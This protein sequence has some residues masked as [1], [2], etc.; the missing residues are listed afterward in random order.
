M[1]TN[2]AATIEEVKIGY[3]VVEPAGYFRVNFTE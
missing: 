3:A 2:P 1:D